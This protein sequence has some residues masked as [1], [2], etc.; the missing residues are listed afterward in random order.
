M[1]FLLLDH[2]NRDYSAIAVNVG[3]K[4][5]A[6]WAG[7][8]GVL[9][10]VSQNTIRELLEDK[11]LDCDGIKAI[12]LSNLDRDYRPDGTYDNYG[13]MTFVLTV[14][15]DFAPPIKKAMEAKIYIPL[16]PA[17]IEYGALSQVLAGKN[18][19]ETEEVGEEQ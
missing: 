7:N 16:G 11:Y 8:R 14:S 9:L 18:I 4:C 10:V 6:E 5:N 19:L 3:N 12:Y 17:L 1:N 13:Y 2:R 15:F